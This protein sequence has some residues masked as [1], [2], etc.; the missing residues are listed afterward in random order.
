MKNPNGNSDKIARQY[1]DRLVVEQRVLGTV[2]PDARVTFLGKSF[3]TPLMG[4][5]LSHLKEGMAG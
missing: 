3:S 5:A 4:A 1:M 2:T